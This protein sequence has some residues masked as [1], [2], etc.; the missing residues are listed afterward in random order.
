[1]AAAD[2]ALTVI[3]SQPERVAA[4]RENV[5]FFKSELARHGIE[6]HT[7]SAIV[8]IRIGDERLALQAADELLKRGF[9]IPAIR[10]PTVKRGEAR[11]RVAIM[12]SHGKDDLARA[13]ESI[14]AA[15]TNRPVKLA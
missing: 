15:C 6:A 11:L 9:L 1:M 14:A 13:A 10:Y 2:A 5:R 3:E 7:D 8:P 12:S 4:L